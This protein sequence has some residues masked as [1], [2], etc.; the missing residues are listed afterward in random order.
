MMQEIYNIVSCLQKSRVEGQ[1]GIKGDRYR[2]TNKH[3]PYIIDNGAFGKFRV[4]SR[5]SMKSNSLYIG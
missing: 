3:V 5:F 4:P 1:K 2:W